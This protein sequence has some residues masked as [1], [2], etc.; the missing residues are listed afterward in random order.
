MD[1]RQPSLL[2]SPTS[3][4]KVTNGSSGWGSIQ[5][6]ERTVPLHRRISNLPPLPAPPFC[7]TH[8]QSQINPSVA[9]GTK[10]KRN[11]RH[12]LNV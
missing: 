4:L 8:S 7:S 5:A 9:N 2:E 3:T 6:Q 10:C 11:C 12:Q 1:E